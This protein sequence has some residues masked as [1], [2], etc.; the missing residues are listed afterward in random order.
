MHHSRNQ[1]RWRATAAIPIVLSEP[2]R[3]DGTREGSQNY[4]QVSRPP[5]W[6]VGRV[7]SRGLGRLRQCRPVGRSYRDAAT[8]AVRFIRRSTQR[9]RGGPQP[10]RCES[11]PPSSSTPYP[12]PGRAKQYSTSTSYYQTRLY[13]TFSL[14]LSAAGKG[15]DGKRSQGGQEAPWWTGR[16]SGDCHVRPRTKRRTRG[17][18]GCILK[19]HSHV[20][21]YAFCCYIHLFRDGRH[22][23]VDNVSEP[24]KG[25]GVGI[26]V[27]FS[28]SASHVSRSFF[29]PVV[30]IWSARSMETLVDGLL[31]LSMC[32]SIHPMSYQRGA[33]SWI[34]LSWVMLFS[35][36]VSR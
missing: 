35:L 22:R 15:W 31:S 6:E 29:G 19:D 11:H 18:R 12:A 4:R 9:R 1:Q 24:E 13:L 23:G 36:P 17:P 33:Q 28:L 26:H 34:Q 32:L 20:D 30:M 5:V 25:K 10:P 3:C 2:D 14:S 21:S 7:H 27:G 8:V 16:R